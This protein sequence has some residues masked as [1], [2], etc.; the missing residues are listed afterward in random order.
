MLE[1]I[2]D[3]KERTNNPEVQA[4]CESALANLSNVIYNNV[5]GDAKV[6]IE[7]ATMENLFN[8]LSSIEEDGVQSWVANGKRIFSVQNLGVRDSINTLQETEGK[9]NPH[10]FEFLSTFKQRLDDESEVLLYE[11]FISGLQAFSYYPQVGS[12]VDAITGRV[13]SYENDVNINKILETM[14]KTRSSYLIPYIERYVENYL[15]DKTEQNKSFLKEALIKFSYDPFVKDLISVVTLDSTNLQLEYA[16]GTCDVDK[17]YSPVIYI[18]ENEAAFNVKGAFYIKKGNHINRLPKD[19]LAKLDEGF[20]QLCNIINSDAVEIIGE[21][22]NVYIGNDHALIKESGTEVNGVPFDQEEAAKMVEAAQW[23]GNEDFLNV[24][25]LIQENFD[26]IAEIDFVKRVFLKEDSSHSADIFKLRDNV[27]IATKNPEEG[28][29][30]FYRNVNPIQAKNIMMEH[31]RFDVSRLF[32]DLLPKEEKIQDEIS[33]TK[34]SYTDYITL[35]EGKIEAFKNQNIN[36]TTQEVINALSEELQEVKDEY[37]DYLNMVERYELVPEDVDV[38]DLSEE[39]KLTIDVNGQKYVVPIP[40]GQGTSSAEATA[41]PVD[42]EQSAGTIPGEEEEEAASAIT[43]DD[44]ETELLGDSPSMQDDEVD[45]GAQE[46]EAEA[47][48]AEAEAEAEAEDFKE[49]GDMDLDL[50]D[51][52]DED[53]DQDEEVE[54]K[55]KKKKKKEESNESLERDSFVEE[56][57]EDEKPKAQ[58]RVFLKKKKK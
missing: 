48:E 32:E 40:D 10:M 31:L 14:K 57:T 1:R 24:V 12:A 25:A 49:E 16:N 23:A 54:K 30:T 56:S 44:D 4:I 18:G 8:Q 47:D 7:N 39:I 19:D 46:V 37:K 41:A 26:E 17:I 29:S 11:E 9:E 42:A 6:E 50:E 28:K 43:F 53:E 20:V 15:N 33:E 36:E 38:S 51:E 22:I 2:T 55:K 21:E 45:L 52:T 13:N 58:K 27:F 34:K 5:T 3:L 35:L